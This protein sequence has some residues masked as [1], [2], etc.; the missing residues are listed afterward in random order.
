MNH[1]GTT[2]TVTQAKKAQE[3][4]R[5]EQLKQLLLTFPDSNTRKRNAN[6][7]YDREREKIKLLNGS[8]ISIHDFRQIKKFIT[9][10]VQP[11]KSA[12]RKEFYE[13][14]YRLKGWPIPT[15]GI[16]EKPHIVASYTNALIYQRFPKDVLPML[17]ELN[18]YVAMGL[19]LRK[20]HQLLTEEGRQQLLNFIEYAISVMGTC[21]TWYE[22]ELKYC[23]KYGL[24]VQIRMEL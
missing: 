23:E 17:Q 3:K 7:R 11:Y 9:D 24:P 10:T 5:R 13:Q 16:H 12:F 15:D 4:E 22:F 8:E 20:H 21:M 18:P 1:M 14:I 2:T 6:A 19:R